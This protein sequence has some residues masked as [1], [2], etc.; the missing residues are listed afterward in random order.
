MIPLN[1]PEKV[2][3]RYRRFAQ[4]LFLLRKKTGKTRTIRIGLRTFYLV[5]RKAKQ[6]TP[7]CLNI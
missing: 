7:A 6:I 2:S 5:Y 3:R 1:P 4:R